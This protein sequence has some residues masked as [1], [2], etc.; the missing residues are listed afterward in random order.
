MS[1][2]PTG[3][4]Q[5]GA[6]ATL[7]G[8]G[9]EANKPDPTGQQ[10]QQAPPAALKF[11][12]Y[13]VPADRATYVANKGWKDTAEVLESYQNLEKLVGVPDGERADRLLI[14]PKSDAKPEEVA[15]F[16]AKA[17]AVAVPEKPEGYGFQ[18]PEGVNPEVLNMAAGAFHAAGVPKPL[19]EKVVASMLAQEQ[20]AAETFV[21]QSNDDILSL[22]GELGDKFDDEMEVAKRAFKSAGLEQAHVD[23]IERAVGTK[24]ML[25]MF[26]TLGKGVMEGNDPDADPAKPGGANQFR[27]NKETAQA[28]M[29]SLFADKE[30][31]SRY[32]SSN[33][34][35]R[36]PA[37][38]QVTALQKV[39]AGE[40]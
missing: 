29:N 39:I 20:A 31:M 18:A 17:N 8:P 11:G 10:Q 15:A 3:V 13:E 22:Q 40:S 9:A 33:M 32:L 35:E 24:T 28:K 14:A 25:N 21:K 19:A 38:E 6:G 36:G 16:L 7:L 23:A 37:I 26:R 2:A 12:E 5:P 30:F 4:E 1:E 27:M 34:R